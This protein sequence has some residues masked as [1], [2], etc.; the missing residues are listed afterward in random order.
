MAH[1]LLTHIVGAQDL[2]PELTQMTLAANAWVIE[3]RGNSQWLVE[4]PDLEAF[5]CFL[6]PGWTVLDAPPDEP[7]SMDEPWAAEPTTPGPSVPPGA[8]AAPD[9]WVPPELAELDSL[10][11]AA[12]EEALQEQASLF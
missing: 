4:A 2:E 9:L 3:Y 12:A 8:P 10:V 11:E 7:D 6:L 1:L 5:H